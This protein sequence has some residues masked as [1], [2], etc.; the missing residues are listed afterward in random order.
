MATV[1]EA[2]RLTE[3]S[4]ANLKRAGPTGIRPGF[5]S[6]SLS[7]RLSDSGLFA[8]PPWSPLTDHKMR[9]VVFSSWGL[10]GDHVK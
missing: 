4:V 2:L 7:D 1:R 5:S 10:N 3:A 6:A 9:M 8:P